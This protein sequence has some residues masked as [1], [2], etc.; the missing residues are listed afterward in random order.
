MNKRRC[1]AQNPKPESKFEHQLQHGNAAWN[2]RGATLG[3]RQFHQ[4][5]ARLFLT[6]A[7]AN[8]RKGARKKPGPAR[9]AEGEM[10]NAQRVKT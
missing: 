6:S 4:A 2:E 10:G 9:H 3:W 5:N 1:P 7:K 8:M